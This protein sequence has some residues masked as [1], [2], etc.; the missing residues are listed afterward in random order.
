MVLVDGKDDP[1]DVHDDEAGG[2]VVDVV[3]DELKEDPL[4]LQYPWHKIIFAMKRFF[5]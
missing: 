5:V 4:N 2:G 1:T 3:M